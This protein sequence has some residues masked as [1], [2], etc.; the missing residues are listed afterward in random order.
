[1]PSHARQTTIVLDT[2]GKLL[3]RGYSMF[4]TCLD[5]SALYRMSAS[6]AKR[7]GGS[8]EVDLGALLAERG[9]GAPCVRMPPV[10]C[11]RCGGRR[12]EC[13]ITTPK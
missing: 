9:A 2:L 5:C 3:D 13:K 8:F 11:P 4:G 7:V 12:T 10:Q 6:A 1:M